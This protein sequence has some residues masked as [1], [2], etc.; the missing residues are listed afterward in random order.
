VA[1]DPNADRSIEGSAC[2]G[3]DGNWVV[4]DAKEQKKAKV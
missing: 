2:R 3:P 4:A 1:P